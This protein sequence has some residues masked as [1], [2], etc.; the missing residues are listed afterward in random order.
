MSKR[1]TQA[2]RRERRKSEVLLKKGLVREPQRGV[3]HHIVSSVKQTVKIPT[4]LS[5]KAAKVE[6]TVDPLSVSLGEFLLA[7]AELFDDTKQKPNKD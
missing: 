1:R 7:F 3:G 5:K 2:T 4:S 6:Q